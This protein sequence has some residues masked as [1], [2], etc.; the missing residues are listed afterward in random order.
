MQKKFL[1]ST[2][3][4]SRLLIAFVLVVLIPVFILS[5]T[6][7]WSGYEIGRQR[8]LDQLDSVATLKSAEIDMWT[9]DLNIG[10]DTLL[11]E[12]D[13]TET[14]LPLLQ[15]QL[16][17]ADARQAHDRV[18]EKL[19]SMMVITNLFSYVCLLDAK[20]RVIVSND[21][22]RENQD[23]SATNY[24]Q[25]GL[26]KN[27]ITPP[28]QE[29]AYDQRLIIV[30]AH[31]ITTPG[32]GAVGVL[33]GY[34]DMSV[35]DSIMEESMGLGQT[36]ESYLLGT[37]YVPLTRLH[38][39][40]DPPIAQVKS[41]GVRLAIE[42]KVSGHA[43]YRNYHGAQ[44][45]GAYT[46]L[47]V[48]QVALV[49]EQDQAE[50]FRVVTTT[51]IVNLSVALAAILL[52]MFAASIITRSIATP[53]SVLSAT[54]AQIAAGDLEHVAE[55]NRQD[56]I[57]KLAQSFNHMTAQLRGL[58]GQLQ[59]ELAERRK[60]E[61]ALRVSEERYRL[62]T[63]N[64]PDI[65]YS[66]DGEGNIVT[67]N[68]PA[69]ERYGYTEQDAKGKTFLGFVHPEDRE[70]VI[71]SFLKAL[72]EQ[73]KFTHGLQFRIVAENG[74]SY[75]FELNAQARFD[76][77]ARYNGE[78]GVLRDI[79]ERKQIEEKIRQLNAELEQ[80]VEKR[81]R[82]LRAAQEKLVHQETLAVMGQLA[83]NVGHELRNPLAVIN[84]AAYYLKL[85]LSGAE[86]KV[87]EYLGIIE[88]ETRNAENIITDLLDYARIK[89]VECE[90]VSV[91][92]LVRQALERFPAPANVEVTLDIPTD[93]LPVFVDP[94]QMI[95]VLG[96]LTTNA[97]QA[98]KE[99]G[100][101]TVLSRREEIVDEGQTSVDG[102]PST[103]TRSPSVIV[104]VKDTGTG[105]TPENMKKLF[106]PLFTTKTKG[107]GLGLAVSKKL[108]EANGG[109][110]EVE[111]E[112]GVGAT[113]TVYLPVYRGEFYN[114]EE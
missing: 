48:L 100:R 87:K 114:G 82:E 79:T 95:Q 36:G 37:D 71:G 101:L 102:K 78:D 105:I 10:L 111:S 75:W 14:V 28:F 6:S 21:P 47:P 23:L 90:A 62:L 65:I 20:G 72:E 110:I 64:V 108:T 113:F 45:M 98:M 104:S 26:Q 56:E 89:S 31:P 50:I 34:S 59:A 76:G 112:A 85:V 2:S 88:T 97:C 5:A 77:N 68:S 92:D 18:L 1:P 51:L 58:I 9:N 4:Y 16:S 33:T 30:A 35:L 91:S 69:F 12:D 13:M 109:R 93:L 38:F 15:G 32:Q 86:E 63:N 61:E 8:T 57:G 42:N 39:Q 67:V 29:S 80:R 7:A 11:S 25:Q 52:A 27:F 81:T 74:V 19:N 106:E 41:N 24:Y 17:P 44:V 96:N 84:N 83:G 53:L 94:R 46:W 107:I 54:A 49:V 103:I 3:I 22:A 66:L 73:R 70:I 55:V 60:A 99:G 40:T 43:V